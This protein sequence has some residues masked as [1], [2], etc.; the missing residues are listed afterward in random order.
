[1]LFIG[2][3]NLVKMKTLMCVGRFIKSPIQFSM[4]HDIDGNI[5]CGENK[6]IKRD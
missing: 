5:V 6:Q 2:I 1:M 4:E 3:I